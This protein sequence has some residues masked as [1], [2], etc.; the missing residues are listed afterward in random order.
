M[1]YE[2]NFGGSGTLPCAAPLRPKGR[3]PNEVSYADRCCALRV[4]DDDRAAGRRDAF[5][6]ASSCRHTSRLRY[7]PGARWSWS[8][9]YGTRRPGTSLRMVARTPSRSA[10]NSISRFPEVA[11]LGD[12]DRRVHRALL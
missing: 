6:F 4:D 5:G 9:T 2:R 3:M 11:R 12:L 1:L 7:R 10:L 8:R